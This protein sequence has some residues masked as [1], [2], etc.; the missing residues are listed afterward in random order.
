MRVGC[1]HSSG[2]RRSSLCEPIN[3]QL[4]AVMEQAKADNA[5]AR[6]QNGPAVCQSSK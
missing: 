4:T 3:R 2:H 1:R 5:L 6:R